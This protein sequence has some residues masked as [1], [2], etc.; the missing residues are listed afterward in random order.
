[1]KTFESPLDS[2]EIKPVDPKGNQ[3]WIFIG[4]TDMKLKPPDV[5]ADS[6]EKTLMLGK[7][8]GKRRRGQP[9]IKWLDSITFSMHMN[10]SKLHYIVKDSGAWHVADRKSTRLNSSHLLLSRMPSSA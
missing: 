7:I 10:W 8:E 6:L 3:P 2:K 9:K 4:G 1:M 5:K